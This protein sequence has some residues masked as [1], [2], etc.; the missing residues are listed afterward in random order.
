VS[1][2]GA[3]ALAAGVYVLASARE[4]IPLQNEGDMRKFLGTSCQA[5]AA[6]VTCAEVG[7]ASDGVTQLRTSTVDGMS[8]KQSIDVFEAVCRVVQDSAPGK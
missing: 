6:V 3:Y 1:N 8:L 4:K 7:G 2:W 5:S